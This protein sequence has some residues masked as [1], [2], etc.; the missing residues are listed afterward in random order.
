MRK[1]SGSRRELN[2]RPS[3]NPFTR[4]LNVTCPVH[5]DIC[6]LQI[7]QTW[8]SNIQAQ[9]YLLFYIS[10]RER[11]SIDFHSALFNN[12]TRI[13]S[14]QKRFKGNL[15]CWN[16]LPLNTWKYYL[17]WKFVE[18]NW[19]SVQLYGKIGY[20]SAILYY[21]TC[22]GCHYCQKTIVFLLYN[23]RGNHETS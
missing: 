18:I 4:D 11:R 23:K 2:W 8:E 14:R 21:M 16:K 20:K 12:Q 10:R 3:S 1:R 17:K 6:S 22:C 19:K 15:H 13:P 9:A 5:S 7:K